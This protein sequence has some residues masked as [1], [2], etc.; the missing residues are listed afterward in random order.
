MDITISLSDEDFNPAQRKLVREAFGAPNDAEFGKAMKK[1]VKAAAL[2]YVN[3][4]VETGMP[5]KADEVRQAR[6]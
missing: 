4:F 3:M 2:E 1:L 6:L 5:S